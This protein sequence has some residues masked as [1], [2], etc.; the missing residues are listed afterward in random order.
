MALKPRKPRRRASITSL[1]DVIFL[2]LLF[3]MLS[4]TFSRFS[5]IEISVATADH[6]SLRESTESSHVLIQIVDVSV[7]GNTVADALLPARLSALATAG[8]TRLTVVPA[9]KIATQRLIDVLTI[10][11]DA[12]GLEVTLSEPAG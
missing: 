11:A 1:I 3:F 8:V 10:I 2:L 9:E 4:S 7:D 12:P 5:E 6:R